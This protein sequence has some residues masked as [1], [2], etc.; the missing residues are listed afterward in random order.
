M[1]ARGFKRNILEIPA[2]VL[3]DLA[4]DPKRYEKMLAEFADRKQA[5]EEAEAKSSK[6]F[7]AAEAARERATQVADERLAQYRAQVAETRG[8]LLA[9]RRDIETRDLALQ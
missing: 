3:I 2:Q 1:P 4:S 6:A 9:K 5:A 8:F 7:V